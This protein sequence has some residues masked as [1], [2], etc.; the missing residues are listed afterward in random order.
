M[1]VLTQWSVAAAAK[2]MNSPWQGADVNFSDVCT[3]TRKVK[4]GDLFFALKGPKYD[5]HDYLAEAKAKGVVAA[6]VSRQVNI[7]L[8]QIVV[9]DTRFA[10]G[11][12]A[13]AH[14]LNFKNPVIGLTGSNGKTTVKELTSAI[15][16]R[17]GQ[18]L[19]TEGNLNN[20][21][22]VPLTL[23]R[24]R[25][26][27]D[28][29]VIEMGAN[30][31]G[32]IAYLAS[33]ARPDVGI[34]NNAGPAHLEGF[35][36]IEGVAHAKGELFEALGSDGVAI[37]NFDDDY[38]HYWQ[39]ITQH[40]GTMSFGIDN[41]QSDVRAHTIRATEKG[42]HFI[43]HTTKQEIDIDLPLFGVHNVR[44]SLAAAAVALALNVPLSVVKT[45]FENFSNVGGRLKS[46]RGHNGA[47][48]LDDT[49]NANPS[50]MKAGIDVLASFPGKRILAVGDM[51]EL[52]DNA[53]ALHSEI[54]AYAKEKNID[55]IYAIGDLCQNVVAAFGKQARHFSRHDE[56][57][58]ALKQ[59]IDAHF[60]VLVKGSR[61]MRMEIVVAGLVG[62]QYENQESH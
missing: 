52:G 58:S 29:A 40:C 51:R 25:A 22:G 18:V 24:L 8:P 6:V 46:V 26:E 44:N 1:K 32:E 31:H 33:L 53:A 3:D 13:R 27:H 43:L 14:R 39:S 28:F 62:N 21:I 35:G 56:L 54:G 7:D 48:V 50:S 42:M 47:L 2:V 20:D 57:L 55:A 45:A 19:Y 60:T 37:I 34:V 15:L 16:K 4:K 9:E 5:A 59:E 41:T 17:R 10:L 36:S 38:A 61:S 23:F 12:L 49:Y 11:E 30:H